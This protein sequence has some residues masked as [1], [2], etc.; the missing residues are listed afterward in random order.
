MSEHVFTEWCTTLHYTASVCR[1][2][3]HREDVGSIQVTIVHVKY[4]HTYM[5]FLTYYAQLLI[6]TPCISIYRI[7]LIIIYLYAIFTNIL[8]I[9]YWADMMS[10]VSLPYLCSKFFYLCLIDVLCLFIC[11][12]DVNFYFI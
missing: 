8:Y 5:K 3:W 11:V 6:F 2:H 9:V 7:I 4:R 10:F 1:R 12:N